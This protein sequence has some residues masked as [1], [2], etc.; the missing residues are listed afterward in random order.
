MT[1][2]ITVNPISGALGAEIEGVDLSTPL[3]DELFSDLNQIFLDHSV[4]FFR[5]QSITPDQ[6]KDFGRH[7]GTLNVHPFVKALEG[8]PEIIPIVK[9]K[10]D[11]ANFG[12]GWH[13]DVTFMEKPALGSVLYAVETP[14]F[15][16]DTLWANQNLA[17]DALSDGMKEM[18]ANLKAVHTADSQYGL[19]SEA[20]KN[21]TKRTMQAKVTEEAEATVIH[22]V[23]RTHP[24]TGRKSLYVNPAFTRNFVGMTKR[25]SRPILQFLYDHCTQ[26]AFTCRFRWEKGSVAFWDNRC[27]QH[28]A[29]NDYH[30]QRREM[31]RVT[32]DGDR[33]A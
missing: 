19:N 7:W 23:V 14:D 31:H 20:S 2:T 33:P 3:S 6:Q 21:N 26:E 15:G 25:E 11:K 32:I 30:G 8:H 16:G 10:D 27:T 9:E 18:L 1:S 22:P 4:I 17:Y 24:E 12:G 13:S 28:Y 29:L 5:D